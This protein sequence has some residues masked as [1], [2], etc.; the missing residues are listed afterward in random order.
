[1]SKKHTIEFHVAWD[2][3]LDKL[4][5]E[6]EHLIDTSKTSIHFNLNS[7]CGGNTNVRVH[8]DDDSDFNAVDAYVKHYGL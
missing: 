4:K 3:S 1:M 7:S 8:T 2:Y 5:D 6:L